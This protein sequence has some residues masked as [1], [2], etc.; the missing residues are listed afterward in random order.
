MIKTSEFIEMYKKGRVKPSTIIKMA[1]FRD[2]LEKAIEKNAVSLGSFK[3]PNFE[4]VSSSAGVVSSAKASE[5][6]QKG[7]ESFKSKVP[8]VLAYSLIGG[9]IITA[10]S[11]IVKKLEGTFVD[12]T[13]D[14]KKPGLFKQMLSLHPELE[15]KRERAKLYYEALWHFSPVMAEN[16]L[17]AGAYIRQALQMDEAAGGPLPQVIDQLTSISKQHAD[18]KRKDKDDKGTMS[19][20]VYPFVNI[21]QKPSGGSEDKHD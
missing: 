16:P 2:E 11:E 5:G 6:F 9:G 7:W 17:A 18:A 1:A 13:T 12:W 3:I 21:M 10:L 20:I 8:E 14:M 4:S 19:N 15:D